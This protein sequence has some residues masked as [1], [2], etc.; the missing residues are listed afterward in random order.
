MHSS[1]SARAKELNRQGEAAHHAGNIEHAIELYR[2]AV[3]LDQ[4][5]GQAYSNLGSAYQK[6]GNTAESIWAN[7]RAITLASENVTVNL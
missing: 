7:R 1:S 2:Q 6:N 4:N 3:N 5:Y